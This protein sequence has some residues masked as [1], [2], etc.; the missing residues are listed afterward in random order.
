MI[1][2]RNKDKIIEELKG[3]I[4][5]LRF[6]IEDLERIQESLLNK[7]EYLESNSLIQSLQNKIDEQAEYINM[8]VTTTLATKQGARRHRL[9]EEIIRQEEDARLR[10]EI[11]EEL[12]LDGGNNDE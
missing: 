7:I 11:R 2:F 1:F 5:R 6:E 8:Y 4:N 12:K 10:K 9:K 3:E